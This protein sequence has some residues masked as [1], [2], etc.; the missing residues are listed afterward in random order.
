MQLLGNLVSTFFTTLI[1]T[2]FI[3]KGF[4]GKTLMISTCLTLLE[5]KDSIVFQSEHIHIIY[6]CT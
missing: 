4:E 2:V 3:V 1:L 6:S 5:A